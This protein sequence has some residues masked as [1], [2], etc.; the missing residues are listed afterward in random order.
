MSSQESFSKTFPQGTHYVKLTVTTH[1]QSDTAL[2]PF[3]VSGDCS[4]RDPCL[5]SAGTQTAGSDPTGSTV[6]KKR[7]GNQGRPTEVALHASA[8]NPVQASTQVAY[9][10]PEQSD[11]TLVV[12]DL[13]GRKVRQLAGFPVLPQSVRF[14][15]YSKALFFLV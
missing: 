3:Y 11:V 9:E 15:S 13:M 5:K 2:Q 10:L 14:G 6:S 1:S 4:L 8:P 7:S 12:Y